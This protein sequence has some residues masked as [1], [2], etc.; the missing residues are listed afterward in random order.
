[1][2]ISL[3][4][5]ENTDH[6]EL[7]MLK[8]ARVMCHFPYLFPPFVSCENRFYPVAIKLGLGEKELLCIYLLLEFSFVLF[9]VLCYFAN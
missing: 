3:I 7:L 8:F 2:V 1:M 5:C 4:A 6:T 9:P